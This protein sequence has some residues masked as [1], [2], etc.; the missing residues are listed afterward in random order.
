MPGKAQKDFKEALQGITGQ[1]LPPPQGLPVGTE[2]L[3][4]GSEAGSQ[5]A[6]LALRRTQLGYKFR[7]RCKDNDFSCGADVLDDIKVQKNPRTCI[8]A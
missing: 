1:G 4:A 5:L 3:T 7:P 8:L 6:Q 2:A